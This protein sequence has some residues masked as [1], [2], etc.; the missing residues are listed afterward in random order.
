MEDVIDH[1][2]D[3]IS[4]E[5]LAI[6]FVLR[7]AECRKALTRQ[8]GEDRPEGALARLE[9]PATPINVNARQP[10]ESLRSDEPAVTG[11]VTRND[12]CT[13][14]FLRAYAAARHPGPVGDTPGRARTV[15]SRGAGTESRLKAWRQKNDGA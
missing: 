10:G 4:P 2:R 7:H 5:E 1:T 9:L 14:R 15:T 11:E 8:T 12:T 13:E 3:I 6:H